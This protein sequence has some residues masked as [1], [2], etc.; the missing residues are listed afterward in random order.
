M[1]NRVISILVL[2]IATGC[3]SMD[4]STGFLVFSD[5]SDFSISQQEWIG[6]F[7]D[8]PTGPDDSTFYELQ[9]KYTDLPSNL[10]SSQKAILL[11]G[12]NHSADL[13]RK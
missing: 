6:D 13:K 2:A 8:Y 5:A 9:F 1:K 10:G 7:A 12:N 11:S 3:A 4:E